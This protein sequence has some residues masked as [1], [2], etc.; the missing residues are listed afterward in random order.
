[1]TN[2]ISD[3]QFLSHMGI[4]GTHI[5]SWMVKNAKWVTS[6]DISQQDLENGLRYLA[7][8]GIIK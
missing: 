6:G 4:Q 8:N 7:S 2:P 1:M 3:T 5:P